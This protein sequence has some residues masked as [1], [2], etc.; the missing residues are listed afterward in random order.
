MQRRFIIGSF[1]D[2]QQ[3]Q[4]QLS[5]LRQHVADERGLRNPKEFKPIWVVDFPLLE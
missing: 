2:K 1:R 4:K 3:T 5:E